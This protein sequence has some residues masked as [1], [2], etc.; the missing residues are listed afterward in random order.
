MEL[1]EQN[2]GAV[3]VLKPTGPLTGTA[4]AQLLRERTQTLTQRS[5]GRLVLDVSGVPFL[6]SQGIESLLDSAEAMASLGMTLR[7]CGASATVRE[8]LRV[9][10][11]DDQFEFHEDTQAGARSFL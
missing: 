6:D 5:L 7:L 4:S 1:T 11:C 3:V 2:V 8:V 10:G 9:T